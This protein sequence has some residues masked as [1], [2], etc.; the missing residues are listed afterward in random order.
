M[1]WQRHSRQ[2]RVVEATDR[3]AM[4]PGEHGDHRC[5]AAGLRMTEQRVGV[6][7]MISPCAVIHQHTSSVHLR[8]GKR[9]APAGK[10]LMY[11][12]RVMRALIPGKKTTATMQQVP[13]LLSHGG[14]RNGTISERNGMLGRRV[15]K[16]LWNT[17]SIS[18][19]RTQ[20]IVLQNRRGIATGNCDDWPGV[21]SSE[22]SGHAA[23]P[24]RVAASRRS[25]AWMLE[26]LAGCFSAE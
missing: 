10:V 26:A 16:H 15:V 5:P 11:P 12:S 13:I 23:D 17:P 9:N 2:Q 7:V 22:W 1:R 24:T 20:P 19:C 21:G 3:Y 4:R 8:R 18:A 25:D 14:Y 6:L